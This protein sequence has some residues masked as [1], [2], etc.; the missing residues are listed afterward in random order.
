MRIVIEEEKKGEI[1]RIQERFLNRLS[2]KEIEKGTAAAINQVT[3]RTVTRL[4]KVI[5]KEYNIDGKYLKRIAVINKAKAGTLFSE[6]WLRTAPVPFIGFKPKTRKSSISITIKKG[7]T[8]VFRHAFVATMKNPS[9]ELGKI[10]EHKGIWFKGVRGGEGKSIPT[11]NYSS[12]EKR[13][14]YKIT[15]YK[16]ASPWSMSLYRPVA[17]EIQSY[18]GTEV[19][20]RVEGILQGKVDKIIGR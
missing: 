5:K 15:E 6:I 9:K 13:Y 10:S 18:M 4:N 8:E 19:L 16:T 20:K 17:M 11:K 7:K 1:R 14:K 3:G 12:K 2:Q